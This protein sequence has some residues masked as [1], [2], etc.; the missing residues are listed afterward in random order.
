MWRLLGQLYSIPEPAKQG[1]VATECV[2]RMVLDNDKEVPMDIKLK[3]AVRDVRN[4]LNKR[5]MYC[6]SAC[7]Q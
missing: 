1:L 7:C 5:G 3:Q 2:C 4:W 6:L